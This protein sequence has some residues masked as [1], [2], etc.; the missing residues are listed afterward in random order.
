M[1]QQSHVYLKVHG[2][3][4]CL[5]EMRGHQ[6][7]VGVVFSTGDTQL[8]G[9]IPAQPPQRLGMSELGF[10][11]QC[12]TVSSTLALQKPEITLC[13]DL[14]A[15]LFSEFVARAQNGIKVSADKIL[16]PIL[17]LFQCSDPALFIIVFFIFLSFSYVTFLRT[18]QL[19]YI[20]KHNKYIMKNKIYLLDSSQPF[21][22]YLRAAQ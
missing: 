13:D 17:E 12:G 15:H 16:D 2:E 9:N 6:V 14:L 22:I 21:N 20:K 4:L 11:T 18:K 8:P 19:M 5:Q 1:S 10:P 7:R 3:R